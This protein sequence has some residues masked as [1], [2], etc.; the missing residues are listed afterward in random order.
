MLLLPLRGLAAEPLT[1]IVFGSCIESTEHPMLDRT[2]TLPM[3]LF[4]FM[5][6]NIYADTTDMAVMRSKYN[7]LKESR[8]FKG[9]TA[10]APILAT[11]DDHDMGANDAGIDYPKR[12]EAQKEFYDWLDEPQ[13]SPRRR[14]EG[15]YEAR[16]FGP[17]GRRTQVIML[18]TRYFRS[19]LKRV[20]KE[21][22]SPGGTA[23]PTDDPSKTMLGAEQWR[24]LEGVLQ[25][26]AE[27]RLLVS[28]IQF[29]AEACGSE[30]WANFPY[31][32][33]R[34][35]ELIR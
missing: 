6:D 1:H 27:L 4:L 33:R 25:Q 10:K 7:R 28:S 30:S 26:P 31:E 5:G 2:L 12:Q 23:V 18:D 16:V 24:W 3:D 20:P 15:V 17:E 29:A 14:Q 35:V 8:F 32:Q 13:D 9:V 11:W 19:P 21:Q 22:A 34:L